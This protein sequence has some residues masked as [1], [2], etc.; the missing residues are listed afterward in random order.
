MI[1]SENEDED[2]ENTEDEDRSDDDTWFCAIRIKPIHESKPTSTTNNVAA[3]TSMENGV[4]DNP[5][6]DVAALF[7]SWAN[8]VKVQSKKPLG[9]QA[10]S[11]KVRRLCEKL[12]NIDFEDAL[13][14]TGRDSKPKL[15]KHGIVVRTEKELDPA[16]HSH[17]CLTTAMPG[18]EKMIKASTK[19]P[20]APL[21]REGEVWA[22]VDTGAGV[23]GISVDKH[24]PQLRH[25]LIEATAK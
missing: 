12:A 6:D 14:E 21:L 5:Q 23:P 1:T 8:K 11:Q 20:G 4:K 17:P 25:K 2:C 24:C 18:R 16:L 13:V 15:P 7:N 9:R 3:L 10:T 19:A 22:M